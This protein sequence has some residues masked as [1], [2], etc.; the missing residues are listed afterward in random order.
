MPKKRFFVNKLTDY[1]PGEDVHIDKDWWHNQI[2]AIVKIISDSL[3]NVSQDGGLYVGGAGVAYMFYYISNYE[4]FTQ[5]KG[6]FVHV[7]QSLLERDLKF[8]ER[9]SCK[10]ADKVSFLLGPTGLYTVGALMGKLMQKDGMV[11]ENVKKFQA[12]TPECVKPNFLRCGSDELFVGRASFLS[13]ALTMEKKLGIKV[14]GYF[15]F[16]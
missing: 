5:Y 9:R 3:P 14:C 13:G 10:A 6:H 4:P 7:A 16:F 1:S 12:I 2:L 15:I 11:Q 8:T